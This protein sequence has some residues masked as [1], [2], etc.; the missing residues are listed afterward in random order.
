MI[1]KTIYWT[2]AKSTFIRIHSFGQ[3]GLTLMTSSTLTVDNEPEEQPVK[4][5]TIGPSVVDISKLYAQT[6]IQRG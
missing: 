3:D 1:C 6:G 2:L 4:E 5:G